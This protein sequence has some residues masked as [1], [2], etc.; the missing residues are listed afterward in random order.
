MRNI[1]L[2][3]TL[4]TIVLNLN[5]QKLS[6]P[7]GVINYQINVQHELRNDL[8]QVVE[9]G[10]PN[11]VQLEMLKIQDNK[12]PLG[13]SIYEGDEIKP[14][15]E[16]L[17]DFVFNVKANDVTRNIEGESFKKEGKTFHRKI[18]ISNMGDRQVYNVMYYFMKNNKSNILYELKLNGSITKRQLIDSTLYD[19]VKT[20][21]FQ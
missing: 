21:N 6:S 19:I 10:N 16:V 20:V 4:I 5:A 7:D 15:E 13:I 12:F 18:T 1:F 11:I 8:L 14:I 9:N 3:L 2:L 17:K